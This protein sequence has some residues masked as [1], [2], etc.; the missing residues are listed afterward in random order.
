MEYDPEP[1]KSCSSAEPNHEWESPVLL[2]K[3]NTEERQKALKLF[4]KY[5]RQSNFGKSGRQAKELPGKMW[6]R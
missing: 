6:S 3:K 1:T 5:F 2:R 4:V